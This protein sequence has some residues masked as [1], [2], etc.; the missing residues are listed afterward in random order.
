M[1]RFVVRRLIWAVPTLLIV[2][3]LVFVAI[4]IGTDPVAE[5][6]ALQ[7]ARQPGPD[8][9]STSRPTA[10]TRASAG[11]SSGYFTWLGGFL[12]GDWPTASRATA[13]SGPSL[14]DAIANSLAPGRHRR[15]PRHHHRPARSASSPPCAGLAVATAASTRRRFVV[16]SHPAVRLGGDPAAGVR[17][18]HSAM[19]PDRSGCLPDLGRVPARPAGLR[20]V[21]MAKHMI[22]PVTVVAIQTIAVYTRYMRASL[23]DV[24]NSDYLRTARSKGISERTV[25]VRHA[26]ATRDP[27]RHRRRHRLRRHCRRPDHH[28]EHLPVPGH[29]RVLPRSPT[30]TA[31]SRS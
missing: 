13:R 5:L 1:L 2:T 16:L 29:G 8:R 22:L 3:F 31:T 19:V 20:P 14:K 24:L 7:P 28:R 9:R 6:P 21:E 4:R 25:L 12:T 18:L 30:R 10:S 27:D 17:R 23:L 26:C 11:T 15:R